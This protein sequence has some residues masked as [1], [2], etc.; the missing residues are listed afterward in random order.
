MKR[1]SVVR[2]LTQSMV[3]GDVG[4]FTGDGVC[5]EAY[6]YDRPGNFYM[7]GHNGALSLALGMAM[8]S[9]RRIFVFCDDS[10]FIRNMS[11]ACQIAV[12]GCENLYLVI[13]ISGTYS[14]VGKHPTIF[15][16]VKSSRSMLFDMGFVVHDY[17][18]QFQ[19]TRNPVKEIHATWSRVRG[20]LA[21]LVEVEY[22]IKKGLKDVPNQKTSI[23]KIME[24]INNKE[25]PY[26]GYVPP[27]TFDDAFQNEG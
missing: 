5:K 21:A 16:S 10:Y 9:K 14:E 20:P 19:N 1:Y 18:R 17:K 12:S 26:Y 2:I 7:P 3:E 13:L 22:S 8:C 23:N 27:I 25:I 4:V 24:F 11:E 15:K 6:A